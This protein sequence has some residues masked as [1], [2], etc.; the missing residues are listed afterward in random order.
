M[1][2]TRIAF[3]GLSFDP[4][5]AKDA[6]A[7]MAAR[8]SQLQPLVY[9]AMAN[10]K[11]VLGRNRKPELHGFH[12]EAWLSLCD[13]RI[14][15]ALARY[16]GL[17]LPAAFSVDIIERLFIQYIKR[18]DRVLVI[19]GSA[20]LAIALRE[21]FNLNDL[22]W[23]DAPHSLS[24]DPKARARCVDFIRNNPAP[25]VFLALGSPQQELIVNEAMKAGG[26]VGVAICCGSALKPV[27]GPASRVASLRALHRLA[28]AP[29]R[30][31]TTH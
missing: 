6:A 14:L 16:S 29:V 30:R 10:V 7:A 13:S 9:V 25:F 11:R 26:S 12:E 20:S 24:A 17:A 2:G 19:G 27:A 8:A 3:F 18:D 15:A 4:L 5:N 31:W 21:R 22:R 1:S 28:F 23:F